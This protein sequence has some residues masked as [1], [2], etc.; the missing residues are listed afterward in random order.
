[1]TPMK[2][3]NLTVTMVPHEDHLHLVCSSCGDIAPIPRDW[4]LDQI[5]QGHYAFHGCHPLPTTRDT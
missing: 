4:Y 2:T 5:I 3:D 1:M